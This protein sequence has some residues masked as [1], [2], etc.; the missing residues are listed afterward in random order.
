MASHPDEVVSSSQA[1]EMEFEWD[2]LFMI[3]FLDSWSGDSGRDR[4]PL[5]IVSL[6]RE[7]N[8]NVFSDKCVFFLRCCW[9]AC[10]PCLGFCVRVY[11]KEMPFPPERLLVVQPDF[12]EVLTE[13]TPRGTNMNRQPLARS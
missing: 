8:L 6:N 1:C 10:L 13:I 2:H 9:S 4:R 12:S 5:V 3:S 11:N 7:W